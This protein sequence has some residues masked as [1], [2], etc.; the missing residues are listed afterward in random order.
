MTYPQALSATP[1]ALSTN[2]SYSI[3]MPLLSFL[4]LYIVLRVAHHPS[5]MPRVVR[6]A[7]LADILVRILACYAIV[8]TVG[9]PDTSTR[10]TG[11]AETRVDCHELISRAL[12]LWDRVGQELRRG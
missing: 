4:G 11:R 12:E 5:T 9:K 2:Y 10:R 1:Q 3:R 6:R 8:S 7:R